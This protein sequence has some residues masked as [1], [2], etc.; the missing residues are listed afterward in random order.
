M[1]GDNPR[2]ENVTRGIY[3]KQGIPADEVHLLLSSPSY[4]CSHRL[5]F[6]D[7]LI[8]PINHPVHYQGANASDRILR[9]PAQVMLIFQDSKLGY[10]FSST[11]YPDLQTIAIFNQATNIFGDGLFYF[12]WSDGLSPQYIGT[13]G[14]LPGR[15]VLH[16]VVYL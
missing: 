9:M 10:P 15:G 14:H 1:G 7:V 16:K 2:V 8:F 5:P 3:F 12:T 13:P 11:T 4:C 6:M